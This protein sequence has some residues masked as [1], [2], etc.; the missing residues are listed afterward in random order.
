MALFMSEG[1]EVC[2]LV[3]SFK[4]DEKINFVVSCWENCGIW[5]G[6]SLKKMK[7]WCF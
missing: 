3:H 7:S 1:D 2:G 4:R 5:K 6:A